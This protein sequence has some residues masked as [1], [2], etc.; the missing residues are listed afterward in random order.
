MER[1]AWVRTIQEQVK[2]LSE[3]PFY[4]RRFH[5][6]GLNPGDIRS[7]EDF[8]KIPLMDTKDLQ[9]DLEENPPHG[10]LFHSETVRVTLSPG[11]KGLMPVYHT[12]QDVEEVN[13]ELAAMY[14][15][16]GVGS[17]DIVAITFGYHLFIA[18]ITLHGGFEALGCKT[19]PLGP[20]ESQ[21]TAEILNRFRVSVLASN[22]SFALKLAQEGVPKLRI[23][24]AGGEPFSSVEGYKEKLRQAF[25]KIGLIDSYGLGQSTPVARECK[26]ERGLHVADNLIFLEIVEPESGKVLSDGERGEVV[27]T[28][29]RRQGS[30][31]FRFRT[32]DLSVLEHFDCTCGRKS[33]LTRG[34]LGRTDEMHKVKGVKL[35]PSQIDHILRTL[36]DYTPGKYRVALTSKAEGGD[37]F[38]LIVEGKDPGP[39]VKEKIIERMKETLLIRPDILEFVER[40][41][42]GPRVVEERY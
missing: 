12:R 33:T 16:C 18:G 1:A 38:R 37:H 39:P 2:R 31:L 5:A 17:H 8:Q 36:S 3:F 14:R 20:G 6:I 15:A 41:P 13:R 42:E 4:L 25:G 30:P 27:I 35:Y 26:E 10:S 21:R 29:L 34:V 28:H 7:P 9:K 11:P 23:L 40:L 24:F 22:P 19:I 32:G